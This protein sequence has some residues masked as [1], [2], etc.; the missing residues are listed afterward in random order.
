[1]SNL[2]KWSKGVNQFS[3]SSVRKSKEKLTVLMPVRNGELFIENSLKMITENI[4]SDDEIIVVDDASS[5]G[6]QVLLKSLCREIPQL[7]VI[8]NKGKGIVDS[9]NLGISEAENDLIARFDVD[10]KYPPQR[11]EVQRDRFSKSTVAL[12]SDYAFRKNGAEFLGYVPSPIFPLPTG[13]SLVNSQRTAHPSVLLNK[14]AVLEVGAYRTNDFPAEDLSLWLRLLRV[15]NLESIPSNLLQYNL[16]LNSTSGVHY[17]VAKQETLKLIKSLGI[18]RSLIS[19]AL[20]TLDNC[21]ANY[22]QETYSQERTLLHVRDLQKAIAIFGCTDSQKRKFKSLFVQ[23]I[24][25]KSSL[26]AG[27]SLAYWKTRRFYFRFKN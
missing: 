11:L 19:E 1:M 5:D 3:I 6:T 9:L 20:E 23:E 4:R 17:K 21:L 24:L 25:K 16:S 12:F 18:P 22:R 15:G 27:I 14:G 26:S 13:I 7:R 8:K 2:N 10:D